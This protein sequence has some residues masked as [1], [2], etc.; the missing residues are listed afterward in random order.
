MDQK[1]IIHSNSL[2]L[3]SDCLFKNMSHKLENEY[4]Q[5]IETQSQISAK[6]IKTENES[7]EKIFAKS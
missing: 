5:L 2:E 6:V 1:C 3:E 7:T 4:S